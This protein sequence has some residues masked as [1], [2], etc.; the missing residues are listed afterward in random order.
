MF[1]E[2]IL[3][4]SGLSTNLYPILSLTVL[5]RESQNDCAFHVMRRP[6]LLT[7][8]RCQPICIAS[9]RSEIISLNKGL[10][11]ANGREGSH[12]SLLL[13]LP[14]FLIIYFA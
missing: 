5:L 13:Y 2:D 4:I 11:Q 14:L 7:Q 12:L 3:A 1:E 8:N 10:L 6:I 9:T